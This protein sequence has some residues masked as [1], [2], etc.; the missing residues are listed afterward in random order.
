MMPVGAI[1]CGCPFIKFFCR[2]VLMG[3][4]PD[5]NIFMN[6]T[7]YEPGKQRDLWE[8]KPPPPIS[9]PNKRRYSVKFIDL[10]AGIGGFR[11]ALEKEG[12]KCVFSSE[13]N[14]HCRMV[15]EK[16]FKDVPYGDMTK[17]NPVNIPEF[18]ILT[19]GFP[20]QPFSISGH[21]KGFDD[22]RGTLFF[23]VARIIDKKE[24][25]LVILEN[26]KYLIHHDKGRTLKIIIKTLEKL[27]YYVSYQLLNA[28]NFGLP[29]NR[30]RIFIVASKIKYFQFDRLKKIPTPKIKD[31]LDEKG[32]F[33]ILESKEYTLIDNPKMQLSGL[34]FVGYRNKKGWKKGVRPNTSHL[35]RVHHQPNRIY[36]INGT[37]PTIP[38]QETSGRFFIYDDEN[39]YVR[40]LTLNEFYKIMGFE[41]YKQYHLAAESYKQIGNSVA[42]PIVQAIA[43]EV[44]NQ[45]LI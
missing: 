4:I 35:S 38:S 7:I 2:I 23:D 37:H 16:N 32:D 29:Q 19:A 25:K 5:T 26:V 43:K 31:F 3:S 42:I 14:K 13:I 1:P 15:Y 17:I 27:G 44:K 22:T 28:N 40:K 10:F 18:E 41:N 11:I 8:C 12:F 33:E 30:E 34:I 21:K 24:P 20:C 36:S 9:H 6:T 39:Q 45:R